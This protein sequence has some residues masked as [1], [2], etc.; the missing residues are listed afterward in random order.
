MV[1]PTGRVTE[2]ILGCMAVLLRNR[3]GREHAKERDCHR[4]ADTICVHSLLHN[5]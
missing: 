3:N 1:D 2:I 5:G 4:Y